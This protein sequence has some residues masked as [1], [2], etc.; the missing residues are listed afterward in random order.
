[1]IRDSKLDNLVFSPS[2]I[3]LLLNPMSG[4]IKK[5]EQAVRD[6]LEQIPNSILCEASDASGFITATNTLIQ[7]NI[8]LLVIIAGDGTSHAVLS[9]LFMIRPLEEWP[10]L[11]I[12]PGGTTNMTP[13]DLG[14]RG[15]PDTVL[16]RLTE[17]LNCEN[18]SESAK[19]VQRPVLRMEQYGK[20]PIYGMFFAV[21]LVARGVKFSRSNIKQIGITG[22]IFTCLIMLRSLVG[23]IFSRNHHEWSPVKM[24][25]IKENGET[26]RGTYLF[27]LVS[28]LDCLLLKIRPFWGK[29]NAPLHMTWVD[30]KHKHLWRSLWP[31]LTGNGHRLK[32]QDGYHSHNGHS[33]TI[34]MDDEYIVDGELYRL[35]G[36]Q[37]LRITATPPVTF[38]VL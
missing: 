9:H 5:Q 30:Q 32:A 4:R 28:A 10:V 19:L 8:D 26:P 34:H 7:A 38:L 18:S 27:A 22:G 21:G 11:M 12:V 13:L 1:M 29:E 24:S 14:M 3:G 35:T 36:D 6:A 33:L 17:Y 23:M 2:R 15:N 25:V 37:P 31:L 16:Y 20:Q